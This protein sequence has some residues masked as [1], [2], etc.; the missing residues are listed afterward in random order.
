M[1]QRV[2]VDVVFHADKIKDERVLA[3]LKP[4]RFSGSGTFLRSRRRMRDL[5][6]EGPTRNLAKIRR[7]VRNLR[8]WQ[9]VVNVKF[10]VGTSEEYYEG[11][12]Q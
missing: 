5:N 10:F 12:S 8:R 9:D 1:K 6:F 2:F 7:A 11:T 3:A 4:L